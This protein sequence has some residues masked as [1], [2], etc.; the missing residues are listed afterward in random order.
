MRTS[1]TARRREGDRV[2][3]ADT[4]EA[5][6]SAAATSDHRPGDADG[7]RRPPRDRRPA[8]STC[9]TTCDA[10]QAERD[11]DRPVA[12]TPRGEVR[13]DAGDP[14]RAED[15]ASADSSERS[16]MIWRA[17]PTASSMMLDIVV[18][19]GRR[20]FGGHAGHGFRAR[21]SSD[22]RWIVRRAVRKAA[23]AA[24]TIHGTVP[25]DSTR[26]RSSSVSSPS[27]T[28]FTTPMIRPSPPSPP[29]SRRPMGSSPGKC[30]RDHRLVDDHDDFV[31]LP[32]CRGDRRSPG[33]GYPHSHRAG[34]VA[35]T[36]REYVNVAVGAVGSVDGSI[37]ELHHGR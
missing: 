29:V 21:L 9:R 32:P 27:A 13:D 33:L 16:S 35:V 25:P 12:L 22:C 36:T 24:G 1:S 26:P 18:V 10:R 2:D 3:R 17:G 6:R 37:V 20:S 5:A 30:R 8:S 19:R 28:F 4:V 15:I 14:D 7:E 31:V 34:V 11:A 23:F